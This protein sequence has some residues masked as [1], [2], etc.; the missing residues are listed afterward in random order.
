MTS[1][2]IALILN[3]DITVSLDAGLDTQ[4]KFTKACTPWIWIHNFPQNANFPA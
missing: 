1:R 3:T 2:S 4:F